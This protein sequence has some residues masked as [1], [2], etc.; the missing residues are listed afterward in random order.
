MHVGASQGRTRVIDA[1]A[2]PLIL[3]AFTARGYRVIDLR[4]LLTP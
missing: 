2:L 4:S 1:E 3:D